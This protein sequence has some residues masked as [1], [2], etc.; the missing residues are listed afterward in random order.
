M[1]WPLLLCLAALTVSACAKK[2]TKA[3]EIKD[4]RAL[5]EGRLEIRLV[6]PP[7]LVTCPA[8]LNEFAELVA[9][10][11]AE[12]KVPGAALAVIKDNRLVC[13]KGFG[14]ADRKTKEPVQPGSL[15]RIASVSKPVTAVAV[16]KLVEQGKL[17][18]DDRIY[19]LLDLGSLAP[20]KSKVDKRWRKITIGHL[21]S[22]TAGFDKDRSLDPMFE[23]RKVAKSLGIKSPPK[24]KDII[25][26]M[27][28]R[29]LDFNP[30]ARYAYSNFGYCLL[31]RVVEEVT[32]K[33]YQSWVRKHVFKPIGITRARIG[34]T[35]RKHRYQGEVS[36]YDGEGKK[37]TAVVGKVGQKVPR[38]DGA[39]YVEAM[40]SHGGWVASAIDLARFLAA[41][42]DLRKSPLLGSKTVRTMLARPAWLTDKTSGFGAD[43][44][45]GLGWR[46]RVRENGGTGNIWHKGKLKGVASLIVRRHDGIAWALLLNRDRKPDG[47]PLTSLI[48]GALHDAARAVKEWPGYD[49]FDRFE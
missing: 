36:Y 14:V 23:S 8:A 41:F 31:G 15:F 10:F 18:L 49:L 32:G 38:P 24:Q 42:A 7:P 33:T 11:I 48:G 47:T 12:H 20:K 40:D 16:L 28:G 34:R 4:G 35:L 1:R 5:L 3:G 19:K 6:R 46:V 22:H 29:K 27:L 43:S 25:R 39:Y 9:D 37:A 13:A 30:G 21:L 26:Y 17:D 44:H 2:G 45:Y